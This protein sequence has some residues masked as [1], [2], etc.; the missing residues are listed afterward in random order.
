MQVM[1]QL[2]IVETSLKREREKENRKKE[3][4]NNTGQNKLTLENIPFNRTLIFLGM[5]GN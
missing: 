4:I 2:W 5:S 3:T 1:A